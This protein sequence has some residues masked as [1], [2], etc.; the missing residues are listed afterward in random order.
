MILFQ[1]TQN[2]VQNILNF[3]YEGSKSAPSLNFGQKCYPSNSLI[4]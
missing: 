1:K 3:I 2:N 4:F